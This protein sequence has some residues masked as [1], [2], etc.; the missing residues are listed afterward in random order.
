MN[1][2]AK[3]KEAGKENLSPTPPI[4][5]KGEEKESTSP[6]PLRVR[7][8]PSLEQA[9]D[10]A[11]IHSALY[12]D[13]DIVIDWWRNMEAVDWENGD[14]TPIK[15]WKHHLNGWY[16]NFA[17]FKALRDPKQFE[18]KP[19]SVW[20]EEKAEQDRI[21]QAKADDDMMRRILGDDY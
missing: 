19:P 3:E 12:R 20:R 4:R 7:K 16:R 13:R 21:A 14:G 2:P 1:N 5:E 6:L 9:L 11:K 10:W 8:Y 15:S 18:R 17:Y